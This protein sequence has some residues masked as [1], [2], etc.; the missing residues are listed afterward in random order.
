[1]NEEIIIPDELLE[2]IENRPTSVPINEKMYV[3]LPKAPVTHGVEEMIGEV[4]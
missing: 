1:M 3:V 2:E 4:E